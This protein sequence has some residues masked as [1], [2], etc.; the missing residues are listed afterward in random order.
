[1]NNLVAPCSYQGGKQR[2]ASTIVDTIYSQNNIDENTK[3][4]DICCGSGAVAIEMINRGFEP[5]NIVMVDN[6]PWGALYSKI[7]KG[8][9]STEVFKL[10]LDAVPKDKALIQEYMKK[11][12]KEPADD[13]LFENMVY[14]F[15]IL[16]A[17]TFGSKPVSEKDGQWNNLSFRNYWLPTE[18]S[19]RKS[20]VNPMMPMPETLYKRLELLV[21]HMEGVQ[22]F[23]EDVFNVDV[24]ENAIVYIDPPYI[25]T[26][27]YK[28]NFD[29]DKYIES[30][31]NKNKI[32]VSEGIKK[33]EQAILLSGTRSKGGISGKRKSSNEEWLS[34]FN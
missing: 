26:T 32:Y 28:Y 4:Y 1:M 19:S 13:G 9:F 25:N 12:S 5:S 18:T 33:S 21:E 31:G 16:Q 20:P 34:I 24:Q 2:L 17:S 23:R 10:H 7:G 6:S 30:L 29:V 22:G 15:L 14:K 8:L 11:L 27:G 3:F